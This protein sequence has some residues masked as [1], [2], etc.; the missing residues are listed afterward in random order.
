MSDAYLISRNAARVRDELLVI[1]HRFVQNTDTI[2]ESYHHWR[3]SQAT[4]FATTIEEPQAEIFRQLSRALT[5][6]EDAIGAL[7][8]TS[9]QAEDLTAK[10][11]AGYEPCRELSASCV[12]SAE[13]AAY[14]AEEARSLAAKAQQE[15]SR[16]SA[17]LS[18]LGS[19]PL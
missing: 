12:S 8:A 3:D 11:S 4:R 19:P 13:A 15:A 16:L 10:I 9:D 2:E 5:E 6:I 1:R 7:G 14:H 17:A 18:S